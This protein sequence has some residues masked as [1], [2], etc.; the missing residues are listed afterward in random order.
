MWQKRQL[1][2]PVAGIGDGTLKLSMR[3]VDQRELSTP[4]S[5]LGTTEESLA[6]SICR[7][8]VRGL[9]WPLPHHL[10]EMSWRTS[11]WLGRPQSPKACF[12]QEWEESKKYEDLFGDIRDRFEEARSAPQHKRH[13]CQVSEHALSAG[14]RVSQLSTT[15]S[16]P[17]I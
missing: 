8:V 9:Q 11:L 4:R 17:Q 16:R 14:Y 1:G 6:I 13:V 12:L 7:H 10:R 3:G 15:M 2:C 5:R